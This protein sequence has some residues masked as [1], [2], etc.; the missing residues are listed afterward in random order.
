MPEFTSYTLPAPRRLGWRGKLLVVL[1]LLA[2]LAV[3]A[4]FAWLA[5]ATRQQEAALAR[6]RAAGIPAS[7]EELLEELKP[8]APE[9][10]AAL[11]ILE[12]AELLDEKGEALEALDDWRLPLPQ[13]TDEERQ[14]WLALQARVADEQAEAI[15]RI[16]ALDAK[17]RPA[18]DAVAADFGVWSKVKAE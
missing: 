5:I 9:R 16:A 18:V 11:D 3:G 8:V 13:M 1:L 12:A 2:L 10:N 6:L 4:W 15:E 14:E 17:I 7:F